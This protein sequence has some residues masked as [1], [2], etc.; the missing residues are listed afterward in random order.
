MQTTLSCVIPRTPQGFGGGERQE[1]REGGKVRR[2]KERG[3]GGR[4]GILCLCKSTVSW[5][6]T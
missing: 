1:E 2:D 3:E 4:E 6:F 5:E